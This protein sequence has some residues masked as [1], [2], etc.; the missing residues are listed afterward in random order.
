MSS[1]KPA[2]ILS[3][4]QLL[5][6]TPIY[7]DVYGEGVFTHSLYRLG[8]RLPEW[9]RGGAVSGDGIQCGRL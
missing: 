2:V 6:S 7:D 1:T 8:N 9:V 4:V 3:Y 5:S